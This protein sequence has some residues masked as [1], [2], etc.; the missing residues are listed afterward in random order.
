MTPVETTV[1]VV[2]DDTSVRTALKRLII[3]LGFRVETL[4]QPKRFSNM[5]LMTDR[6]V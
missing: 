5:D 4:I 3:S 1:F 2:D 6:H